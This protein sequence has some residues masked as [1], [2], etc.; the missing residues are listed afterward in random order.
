MNAIHYRQAVGAIAAV[1]LFCSAATEAGASTCRADPGVYRLETNMPIDEYTRAEITAIRFGSVADLYLTDAVYSSVIG[2]ANIAEPYTIS[3]SVD[4]KRWRL[5]F[6]GE[7][8][9]SGILTLLVP[10]RMTAYAAD[11]HDNDESHTRSPVLYKEW[12]FEGVARGNGVFK[13]GFTASARYT[14]VFQGRG[15][16]C[17]EGRQFTHWRLEVSGRK[18]G[19]AF[20]GKLATPVP[21]S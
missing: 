14:L 5:S 15:N 7:N 1:A 20:F 13:A 10:T 8:G 11:I 12:R 4:A 19:Y 6:R 9:E 17:D 16:R 2:I 3:A 21:E 18:A